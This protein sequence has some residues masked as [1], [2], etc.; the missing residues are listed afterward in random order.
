MHRH[1]ILDEHLA[2]VPLFVG[3]SKKQLRLISELATAVEEPA[4]TV[5]IEQGKVGHEFIV[6]VQGQIEVNQGGRVVGA[7]GPGGYVGEI[8][9][10]EQRPRTANVIAKTAVKLEVINQREFAGLL[11]E[12]PELARQ[13]RA[14]AAD[15]LANAEQ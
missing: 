10:L 14:L 8:A 13:L 9:L 5:L 2:Q 3:L 1:D 12:M 15:R 6:V 4:G 7:H 11:E